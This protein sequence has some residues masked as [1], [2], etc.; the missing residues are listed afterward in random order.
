MGKMKRFFLLSGLLLFMPQVFATTPVTEAPLPPD[1][2]YRIPPLT[3]RDQRGDVFEFASLRGK[4]LLVGM[5]YG[6][7]K[8]VCPLEI[9]ALKRIER[10][11]APKHA[12]PIVLV[13]FD[14][15]NDD[16]A[17]LRKVA[18]EHHVQ[19]PLFRLTRPEQGDEGMLAG[20]L[21]IAYR[22]MPGGGFSHNVVLALLDAEG[23]I[24]ATSDSTGAPD[25]EF[26]AAI[27]K[28]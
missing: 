21:G 10:K 18:V 26:V 2:V 19:A 12:I 1:S 5:F 3:L 17:M 15:A 11:V 20:V 9:E 14:P 7:C 13:S 27:L 23:R 25:P 6:S 4:P 16:V 24:V 22:H 8:M 28:L